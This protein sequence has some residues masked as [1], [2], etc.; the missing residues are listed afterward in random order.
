MEV[1]PAKHCVCHSVQAMFGSVAGKAR[2]VWAHSANDQDKEPQPRPS[3]VCG[4]R[5]TVEVGKWA[6]DTGE[7]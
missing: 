3:R 4:V 1:E 6:V 5:S 2:F 7:W